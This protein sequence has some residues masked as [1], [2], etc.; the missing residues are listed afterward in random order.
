LDLAEGGGIVDP[1][2]AR[3]HFT[4]TT[5]GV[6]LIGEA[7]TAVATDTGRGVSSELARNVATIAL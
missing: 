2:A 1:S 3:F 7:V 4:I 6:L 5:G